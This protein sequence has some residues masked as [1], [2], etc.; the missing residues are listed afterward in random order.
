MLSEY[1]SL[2]TNRTSSM[3]EED[4]QNNIQ[5]LWERI[6]NS[7]VAIIGAAGSIGFS[8]VKSIFRFKPAGL[9]LIDISENNLVEVVRDCRSSADVVVPDEFT[10][11][12][13]GLG[14]VE[15]SRFFRESNPFDYILNLSAIKHVRSEKNVYCLSR[16]IDVNISYLAEFLEELGYSA[17]KF[18]SVSSDKAVNPAN[19]M[20]ASKMVM[21][22]ILLG[23]QKHPFS[24]ARFANVAFSDGSLPFGFLKRIEKRQPISSPRDVKRFFISH[25]EAGHICLLSSILGENGDV[26][27]PILKRDDDEKTFSEIA[28]ILLEKIGYEAYE[29]S[30][31]EE[32]RQDIEALIA[33]KKWPCFFFD[34]DTTGEKDHEEFYSADETLDLE[35]YKHI[36][37]IKHSGNDID[38]KV[39]AEFLRFVK[40]AKSNNAVKKSDYVEEFRKVVPTLRH[41]ETGKS[42]DQK[43]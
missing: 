38:K 14:S 43:M 2:A 27:F 33:Q 32:A 7:R 4:V 24:T 39:V 23:Q 26:Y 30:S 11:L 19:L 17:K 12:P 5:F 1:E 20:G 10:V 41:V 18:F 22:K 3:F 15:F 37:V 16:M 13:V 9:A 42:L 28:V 21:E 29:C 34:S 8:V 36:G 31:E 40:E 25:E 6:C 35:S